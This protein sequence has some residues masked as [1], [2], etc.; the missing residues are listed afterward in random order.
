MSSAFEDIAR[1]CTISDALVIA[2]LTLTNKRG[3]SVSPPDTKGTYRSP[4]RSD[5]NP[6]FSLYR[7]KSDQHWRFKDHTTGKGGNMIN[8]VEQALSLSRAEA[9]ELI[10]KKLSLGLF[11]K[12]RS[13]SK[14]PS[15]ERLK[16][17]KLD[18]FESL[19]AEQIASVVGVKGTEG[20]RRILDRGILGVGTLFRFGRNGKYPEP[21]C[22]FLYDQE[23][24]SAVTR[25]LNGERFGEIKSVSPN[26]WEKKPVGISAIHKEAIYSETYEA[27]FCEGE[28]DLIAIMHGISYGQTI[29]ICMPSA[30]TTMTTEHAARFSGMSCTIYAQADKPGIA[31]ALQWYKWLSH[32][33]FSVKIRVPKSIGCDWADLANGCTS[34]EVEALLYEA[35]LYDECENEEILNLSPEAFPQEKREPIKPKKKGGSPLDLDN[36][37]RCFN[38]WNSLPEM[39][40]E[41]T[42]KVCLALGIPS[43]GSERQRVVRGLE[44]CFKAMCLNLLMLRMGYSVTTALPACN[45]SEEVA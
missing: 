20:V 33:A 30:T 37:Y 13:K 12:P 35:K 11:V 10:D 26:D 38:A 44:N 28:K 21:D 14:S 25:K 31:A 27:V 22:F 1:R 5:N 3:Q 17:I 41:S 42:A 32:Y 23:S 34:S 19:H 15:G 24:N 40:R 9:A 16:N 6:S 39:H 36:M 4:F 7:D 45:Y 43:R 8:L 18:S 29:P 2:G